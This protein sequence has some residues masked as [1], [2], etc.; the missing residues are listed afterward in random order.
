MAKLQWDQNG[1]RF[2]ETGVSKGVLFVKDNVGAYGE[3]VA[4][5][6]LT[7][8][9]ENPTGGEATAIYADNI[10]YLNLMSKEEFEGTIEA[11]TYPDEF[12]A[13]D[14][15]ANFNG[16]L[17]SQQKRSE[18]GFCYRTE[19]GNDADSEFGYKLHFV[20]GALASPSDK[21]HE[22]VND[23]PEAGTFSWDFTTT[24][25]EVTGAKPTAHIIVDSRKV[26]S[27]ALQDIENAVYGTND[28]APYLP[29]PDQLIALAGGS[30]APNTITGSITNGTLAGAAKIYTNGTAT[31]TV[32]PTTD[33]TY[34]AS[35][36]VAN[37][38]S[39]SYNATTGVLVL[40][41]PTGNVTVT[42]T[43]PSA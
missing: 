27:S 36:T 43:C 25:V 28:A 26:G 9:N 42:A 15:S 35:V 29:L 40:N 7:A 21:D 19:I 17:V 30:Q 18:F 5:N 31:C 34:P 3:G 32:S 39:Y 24:P 37:V 33:Y 10:K 20:Y 22:T 13:C 6:G 14:G 4:W 2:Y 41:G 11:Y 1:E 23:S 16:V 8:V 38:T 12:E